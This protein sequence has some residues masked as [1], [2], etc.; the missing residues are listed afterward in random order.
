MG[1]KRRGRRSKLR[2]CSRRTTTN[3]GRRELGGS[4]GRGDVVGVGV[5]LGLLEGL[6]LGDQ[7]NI[8][9]QKLLDLSLQV[10]NLICF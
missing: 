1:R 6:D 5:G 9:L 2:S 8:S 7:V 3:V 10:S 4:G